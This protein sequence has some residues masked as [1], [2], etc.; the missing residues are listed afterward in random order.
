MT[1]KIDTEPHHLYY[2][3]QLEQVQK[4]ATDVN[5]PPQ[6]RQF[7]ARQFYL[8]T[9]KAILFLNNDN[10]KVTYSPDNETIKL[11]NDMKDEMDKMAVVRLNGRINAYSLIALLFLSLLSFS[12]FLR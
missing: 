7:L 9:G 5:V 3:S 4:A 1:S 8:D 2:I 6:S 12:A 10:D 11:Q